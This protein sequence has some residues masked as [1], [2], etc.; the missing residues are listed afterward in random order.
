MIENFSNR[1]LYKCDVNF[2]AIN[3]IF[4]KIKDR[5]IEKKSAFYCINK[6]LN[7]TLTINMKKF[8]YAVLV[9]HASSLAFSNNA[10]KLPA[11][12]GDISSLLKDYS[13]IKIDATAEF[14]VLGDNMSEIKKRPV[15]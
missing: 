12:M 4:N 3:K 2:L 11:N 6:K 5:Y 10:T 9:L 1:F 14:A 8:L 15:N 13:A 7:P